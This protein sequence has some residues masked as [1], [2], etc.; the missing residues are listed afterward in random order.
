MRDTQNACEK[1][2]MADNLVSTREVS[3]VGDNCDLDFGEKSKAQ[4]I[5][6]TINLNSNGPIRTV[7]L[8]RIF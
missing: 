6:I 5:I 1:H 4:Q 2:L 7:L 3:F 8:M